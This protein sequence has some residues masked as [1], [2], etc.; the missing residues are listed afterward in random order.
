MAQL[1]QFSQVEQSVTQTQKLDLV[2]QQLASMSSNDSVG[3]V[4]K[5][6]TV[7]AKQ[8]A[9]DGVTATG[10]GVT[11]SNAASSVSVAIH[12]AKG[13]VV[14][15]MQLG[16]RPQGPLPISWDGRDNNG[17]PVAAGSY[18]FD[19]TATTPSGGTIPVT[20]QVTGKV[21]RVSF[22]KGYPEMQLDSGATA[23][24]SDLISVGPSALTP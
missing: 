8:I 21:A 7:Q 22:D 23:P 16:A 15:T 5:Q 9:F 10:A 14:R 18:G 2:S 12:D 4:G 11:L 3:L 6:V 24:I 13:D 1:A 17:Q 19:V 20:Q